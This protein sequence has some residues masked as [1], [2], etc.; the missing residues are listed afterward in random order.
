MTYY[1]TAQD[2]RLFLRKIIPQIV[3]TKHDYN[4]FLTDPEGIDIYDGYITIFEKESGNVLKRLMLE[5]K[6]RE[7]DYDTL[8]FEKKKYLNLKRK[9]EESMATI[10]Y[11]CVTP[12][13]T[14][15]FNIS[16]LEKEGD[17]FK[18]VTVPCNK[19]TVEKTG[20][21]NKLVTFLD[22]D[23]SIRYL[24]NRYSDIFELRREEER[25]NESLRENENHKKT[26]CLY[27]WLM[28]K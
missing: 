7:V 5:I 15:I 20:K 21:I 2:E 17:G 23:K 8:L 14:Y 4:H 18:F 12:A 13:G 26:I 19:S 28:K 3:N 10:L 9:A 6:I 11:I 1:S 16:K 24:E 27:E 25:T 22:K